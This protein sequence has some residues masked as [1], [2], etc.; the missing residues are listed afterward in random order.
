MSETFFG[1]YE[2]YTERSETCVAGGVARSAM[3]NEIQDGIIAV[4]ENLD[5]LAAGVYPSY[6]ASGNLT[7]DP[8]PDAVGG[9]TCWVEQHTNGTTAVVLDTTRDWRDRYVIVEGWT[10]EEGGYE[11]GGASDDGCSQTLETG[12][13]TTPAGIARHHWFYTRSGSNGTT[14][15]R[16]LLGIVDGDAFEAIQLYA[17]DTDGALIMKKLLHT[18]GIN[19]MVFL[20]LRASPVQNHHTS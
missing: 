12:T 1:P 14:E 18:S 6:T 5:A 13:T 3:M 17:R 4:S 16:F 2:S 15:P 19:P 8:A 11:A 10:D 9:F 20:S 7:D